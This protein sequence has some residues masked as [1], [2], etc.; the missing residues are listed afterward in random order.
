MSDRIKIKEIQNKAYKAMYALETYLKTTLIDNSVKELI[1][2]RA[3]QSNG[4]AYC[5]QK[6]TA[7][8]LSYGE[9]KERIFALAAWWDSPLFSNKEQAVLKATDEI[10]HISQKGLTDETYE[11]L[12]NFFNPVEIAEIIMQIVTINAWNRIA[13]SNHLKHTN[14]N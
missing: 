7:D 10:T 6:H 8:A 12:N 4:C 13:I 5:I 11:L 1:K 14:E 2:I 3:S 9:S